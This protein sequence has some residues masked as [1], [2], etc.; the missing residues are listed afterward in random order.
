[1][2][3]FNKNIYKIELSEIKREFFYT[4]LR[5]GTAVIEHINY[6]GSL[7]ISYQMQTARICSIERRNLT[8]GTTPTRHEH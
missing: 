8:N 1:M 2:R 6:L 4:T 5:N 3:L 7:N